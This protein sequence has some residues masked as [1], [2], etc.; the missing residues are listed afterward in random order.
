MVRSLLVLGK[1]VVGVRQ[2]H[3]DARAKVNIPG[4]SGDREVMGTRPKSSG[5]LRGERLLQRQ[6][7]APGETLLQRAA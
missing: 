2:M 1:S 5:L 4:L 7:I 6:K 3:R